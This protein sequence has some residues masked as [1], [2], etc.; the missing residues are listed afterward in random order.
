MSILHL[1]QGDKFALSKTLLLFFKIKEEVEGKGH[2]DHARHRFTRL[3][4][5][6]PHRIH[7]NGYNFYLFL[8]MMKLRPREVKIILS[9]LIHFHV[10]L[11]FTLNE[12]P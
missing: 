2:V 3:N 1:T 11:I 8:Q 10:I 6:N 12:I 5:R 7:G 9:M 4:L